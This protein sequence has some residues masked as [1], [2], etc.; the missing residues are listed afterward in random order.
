MK[1]LHLIHERNNTD[2]SKNQ[3]DQK[4][5]I[6]KKNCTFK[7][8][9]AKKKKNRNKLEHNLKVIKLFNKFKNYYMSDR[10]IIN[11]HK[12]DL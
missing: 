8:Y 4:T 1:C 5:K 3:L 2:K 6:D 11:Y 7:F 12:I 9:T 10:I